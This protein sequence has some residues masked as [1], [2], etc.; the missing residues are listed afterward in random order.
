M[1]YPTEKGEGCLLSALNKKLTKLYMPEISCLA[2]RLIVRL[3]FPGTFFSSLSNLTTLIQGSA[4]LGWWQ[5]SRKTYMS[6]P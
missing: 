2:P 3:S 6:E 1:G 4:L 5:H